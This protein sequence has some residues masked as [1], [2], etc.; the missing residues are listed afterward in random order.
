VFGNLGSQLP[1]ASTA[2]LSF[3]G[4]YSARCSSDD[5]AHVLQITPRGGAPVLRPTP[6]A[7][8]GLH[9]ADANIA[10]GDVARLVRRQ[11]AE[12]VRSR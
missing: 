6:A 8:S 9:L 2:W 1:S 11:A 12:Y 4:S 5:G 3:P 7:T 10:L